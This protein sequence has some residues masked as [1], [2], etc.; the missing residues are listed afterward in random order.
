MRRER[1]S[2]HAPVPVLLAISREFMFINCLSDREAEKTAGFY[3]QKC[4]GGKYGCIA[5]ANIA[6]IIG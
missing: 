4:H 3:I 6:I 1:A 5:G 2:E